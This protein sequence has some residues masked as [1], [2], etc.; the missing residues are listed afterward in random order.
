[1]QSPVLEETDK[2]VR[3]QSLAAMAE[4]INLVDEL[5][6]HINHGKAML[7][8]N[9]HDR[10]LNFLTGILLTRVFNSLWRAREDAV[11]GYHAESLTGCRA[12]LEHWVTARWVE[13]PPAKR[14][15]TLEKEDI[16]EKK[17]MLLWAII[18]EIE[19]PPSSVRVPSTDD[20]LKELG[21]LGKNVRE[22][23]NILSKFA[24]PRSIG[25]RWLIHWDLESTYF[26]VGGYFD[27]RGLRT[28]LYF[29]MGTA[30]ASL[31]SVARLQYRMLGAVDENWLAKGKELSTRAE[32]FMRQTEGGVVADARTLDEPDS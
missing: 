24:H 11:L 4:E 18:D 15:E 12:A 3:A 16:P 32:E 5:T 23:Y 8:G 10:G 28:C 13:L 30:Q 22:L 29:L 9:K 17:D 6:L 25:L 14:E 26:H 21:S 7:S 19:R 1:M 27:E 2:E 20:M 31:E